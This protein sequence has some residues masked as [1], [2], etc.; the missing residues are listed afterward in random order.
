MD[1]SSTRQFNRQ[2]YKRIVHLFSFLFSM[3]FLEQV[4]Q[5]NYFNK[6]IFFLQAHNPIFINKHTN[7]LVAKFDSDRH[8]AICSIYLPIFSRNIHIFC[9][10]NISCVWSAI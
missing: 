5:I 3:D 6:D 10:K 4:F 9:C 1:H 2:F 7:H 8:K